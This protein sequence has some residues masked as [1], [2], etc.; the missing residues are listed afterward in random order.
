MGLLLLL[1]VI[2]AAALAVLLP[3]DRFIAGLQAGDFIAQAAYALIAV[4][5]LASLAHRYRGRMGAGLRDAVLW[6]CLFGALVTA[7]AYRDLLEPIRD[8]VLSELLPGRVETPTPGVAEVARRRDGHFSV[9]GTAD[10]AALN[11]MFDTGAS[12]VVLRGEDAKKLGLDPDKLRYDTVVSTANGVTRAAQASINS[13]SVGTITVR[14]VRAT[15]ARPGTLHENL[16][17]QSF[18]EKLASYSVENN[19]LVM[20][21]R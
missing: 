10:G 6:V 7:Y 12:T 15:I 16:L 13:L 8:R 21:T 1:A 2:A 9:E 19:R 4:A 3:G 11:F 20:R 5:L 14:N 17:G 18:L